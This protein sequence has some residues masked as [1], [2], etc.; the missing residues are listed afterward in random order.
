LH[1]ALLVP[2]AEQPAA[3]GEKPADEQHKE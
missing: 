1:E 2:G 3:D